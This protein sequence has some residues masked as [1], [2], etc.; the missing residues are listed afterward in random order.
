MPVK[1]RRKT[2]LE[3]ALAPLVRAFGRMPTPKETSSYIGGDPSDWGRIFQGQQKISGEYHA[4]LK[5]LKNDGFDDAQFELQAAEASR[6]YGG[7]TRKGRL[8]PYTKRIFGDLEAFNTNKIIESRA[9][10]KHFEDEY[11]Y[12]CF[13]CNQEM[14]IDMMEESR[15]PRDF[16]EE[17]TLRRGFV[18]SLS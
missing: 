18:N 6:K 5:V 14:M 7:R 10:S 16:F 3:I 12:Y 11:D 13:Y 9:E 8:I 1:F 2:D 15:Y 17:Q 4:R